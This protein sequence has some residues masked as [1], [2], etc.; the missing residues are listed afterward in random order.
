MINISQ[1]ETKNVV[2]QFVHLQAYSRITGTGKVTQRCVEEKR[3]QEYNPNKVSED[4]IKCLCAIY[5]R[6]RKSGT[7]ASI[8]SLP[9]E[10]FQEKEFG[11]PF[12]LCSEFGNRDTG[13]Y[14]FSFSVDANSI[15][16]NR[17]SNCLFLI[18]RLR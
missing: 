18:Q 8:D 12:H 5:R 17:T 6:M 2:K 3:T 16:I 14:K 7:K 9:H 13:P 1:H 11:N 10:N 15:N 4:I